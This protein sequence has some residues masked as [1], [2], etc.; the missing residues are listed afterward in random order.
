MGSSQ[1]LVIFINKGCKK[2]RKAL[3]G[4]LNTHVVFSSSQIYF[5]PNGKKLRSI[6][7]LA[8]VFVFETDLVKK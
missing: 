6:S 3:Q 7:E 2:V 8:T 1:N 4:R 5:L